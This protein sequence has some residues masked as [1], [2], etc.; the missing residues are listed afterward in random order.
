MS[1][2]SFHNLSRTWYFP[3]PSQAYIPSSKYLYI[4]RSFFSRGE[5]YVSAS[6]LLLKR[7]MILYLLWYNEASI[8]YETL[9]L[10]KMMLMKGNKSHIFCHLWKQQKEIKYYFLSVSSHITVMCDESKSHI[11]IWV[12]KLQGEPRYMLIIKRSFIRF[13]KAHHKGCLLEENPFGNAEENV[14][15]LISFDLLLTFS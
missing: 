5:I 7:N 8:F 15:F 6:F 12:P 2:F 4:F 13:T 9:N 3:L 10:T 11:Y 1:A 14:Q